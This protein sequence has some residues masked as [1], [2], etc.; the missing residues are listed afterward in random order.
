MWVFL[1]KNPLKYR[2]FGRHQSVK[3]Y[4]DPLRRSGAAKEMRIDSHQHFWHYSPLEHPWMSDEMVQLRRD[5]LPDDL[6]PLLQ[7]VGFDGCIAVQASQTLNETSWLLQLAG[8]HEFIK[9]VV[10]W[11]D[12]L[13]A[14]LPRQLERFAAHPKFVG[15][16]HL[17]QD[18]PDDEFMLRTD[19]VNGIAG[20][21]LFDLTYDLLVFPKH[22]RAAAQLVQK[23]PQQRFVLD[24][25]AKPRISEGLVFPWQEGLREL[26][27]FQNVSCK[28]SGMVTE[29][30]WNRWDPA[31]F[32]IYLDTVVEAFT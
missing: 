10:G 9:G 20:L 1:M 14:D 6:Y 26:A 4:G 25:M 31:E 21:K 27:R 17:V 3:C 11:V 18:E 32:S 5:F 28:L 29:A 22:L 19:F 13:S 30:K 8:Q 23:F 7:G 15:V 12:L 2:G 16:R 24:H